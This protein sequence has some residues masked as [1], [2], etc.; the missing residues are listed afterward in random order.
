MQKFA[1][2]GLPRSGTTWIG[3]IF[4]SSPSVCYRYQPLFSYAL[5]GYLS[6]SS[7]SDEIDTFYDEL[8]Q[9]RD[10]FLLQTEARLRGRLPMFEKED[11]THVGY[12]EVR[13]HQILPNFLRRT[14][15]VKFIFVL[16]NPLS[17]V[18]SWLNAPREFRA[19]LGWVR[20]EEWR[21]ALKKNLNRPEEFNGYDRWKEATMMFYYLARKY[22]GRVMLIRYDEL[23]KEPIRWVRLMFDFL[24]L[25]YTEQTEKFLVC[26]EGNSEDTYSV[27]RKGQTDDKWRTQLDA[28]IVESILE[29]IKGSPLESLGL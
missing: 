17:V 12:K 19:D 29:D 14:S 23:L 4:N 27:K 20:S 15:D 6:A 10:E 18:N 13:Y 3:E 7:S 28:E 22:E 21:Y 9:S 1:I 2:H 26:A 11:V 16:R 24:E 25:Q 8:L 5:K